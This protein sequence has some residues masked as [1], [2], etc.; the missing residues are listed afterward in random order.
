MSSVEDSLSTAEETVPAVSARRPF[1]ILLTVSVGAMMPSLDSTIVA[2]AAPTIQHGLGASLADIQWMSNGYALA[3]IVTLVA[4]GKLGDRFG[5]KVIF[6]IGVLGFCVSSTAVGSSGTIDWVITCRVLQGLFAAMI[7]PT[8]LALLRSTFS[9]RRLSA[10]IGIWTATVVGSMTAGPIVGGLLVQYL[11]WQAAFFIN[12]PI[13]VAAALLGLV[14]LRDSPREHTGRI[15][16]VGVV[17]LSG[18]LFPLVWGLINAPDDGWAS[19]RTLGYLAA[20]VILGVLFVRWEIRTARPLLPMR[21]FRSVPLTIGAVLIILLTF[22][23]F[24]AIF[25]GTFYFQNVHGFDALGTGLHVLSLIAGAVAGLLASS[26]V[27]NRFGVRGP[28]AV[29]MLVVAVA[30]FALSLTT[31]VGD[32]TSTLWWLGVLGLGYG[33]VL[34]CATNL[35]LGS[36]PVELAGVAG[37]LQSTAIQLGSTLGVAVLGAAMASRVA[38]V[39]PDLWA[40]A[41]LPALPAARLEV[42]EQ[43]VAVGL[44]PNP[45]DPAIVR[46]SHNTF[47]DGMHTVF[48]ISAAVA[49]VGAVVALFARPASTPDSV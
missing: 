9:G 30:F 32:T 15:D 44:S 6:L 28:T 27:V 26:L 8:A 36:A 45:A 47:L 23:F 25:I 13:A 5:H 31:T 49:V 20:A 42:A 29:N 1:L 33:Q 2:V 24:G 4:L 10:A 40:S 18:A 37:A 34:A 12:V 14:V 16:L 17:L 7:Q 11:N 43:V 21:L 46:L 19:A 35:V 38:G 22:A 39:L 48:L 3:L 41:G